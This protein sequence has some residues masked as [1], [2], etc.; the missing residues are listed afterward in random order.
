MKM[1]CVVRDGKG[2][3]HVVS[4]RAPDLI[5]REISSSTGSAHLLFAGVMP[6]GIS[7]DTV[8]AHLATRFPSLPGE[9]SFLIAARPM[10]VAVA[11]GRLAFVKPWLARLRAKARRSFRR[12]FCNRA[13]RG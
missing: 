7:A 6:H 5:R 13:L 1:L 8:V 12:A 4:T 2:A 10:Q 11:V 3:L 9:R